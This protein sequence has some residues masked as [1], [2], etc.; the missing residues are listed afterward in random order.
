VTRDDRHALG[1]LAP[2]ASSA[3]RAA[4]RRPRRR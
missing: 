1:H 3:S 2:Q 4:A